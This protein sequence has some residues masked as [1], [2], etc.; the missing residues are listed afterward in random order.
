MKKWIKEEQRR[1]EGAFKDQIVQDPPLGHEFDSNTNAKEEFD[2]KIPEENFFHQ[3]TEQ[4]LEKILTQQKH[5]VD[6]LKKHGQ[7]K[8]LAD[9]ILLIFDDLG[10]HKPMTFYTPYTYTF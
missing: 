6:A 8:Y 4:D 1:R 7:P 2:G 10:E 5:I 3:Y 9:R